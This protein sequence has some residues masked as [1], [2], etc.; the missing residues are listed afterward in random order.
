M[1]THSRA[2]REL[3]LRLPCILAMG[4]LLP[5]AVLS[6]E[7]AAEARPRTRA[8]YLRETYA[9]EAKKHEF[10]HDAARRQ[11]LSL[12][13]HPVM[14]WDNEAVWSGDVF[15]W[16]H[17]GRPEVIGCMLSGPGTKGLRYVY[18]EFHLV[19]EQLIAPANL[20][21]RRRWAPERGLAIEALE[22]AAPPAAKAPARLSQM[23]KI[24]QT[25][26]AH[27]Q[28]REA[29][30]LRLLPQPLYRYGDDQSQTID[31]ALFAYVWTLGTDP[32]LILLLECRRS[33]EQLAWHY[34]P[35]RFSNRSLWLKYYGREV[36]RVEGH[37]EPAGKE[38]SLLY[39]T[40]FSRSI[41]AE[42]PDDKP[43]DAQ[44]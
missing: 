7:P 37:R 24:S 33:G 38:T 34:A 15:V 20:Q 13:D 43:A 32:E 31:G 36:W 30:E 1:R 21:T 22:G 10:Y 3:T 23:R 11:P 42:E 9:E 19:A 17:A 27:M 40:A 39:T 18:N 25:F 26:T 2:V 44:P 12:V 14:N 16:T 5:R 41:P 6:D 35:V 28:A 8:D 29:W 4:L